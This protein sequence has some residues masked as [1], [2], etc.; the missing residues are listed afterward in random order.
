MKFTDKETVYATELCQT[1][2]FFSF[3]LNNRKKHLYQ[4][5][6]PFQFTNLGNFQE[7]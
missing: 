1:Q 5:R 7:N 6:S 3:K 2:L 4:K